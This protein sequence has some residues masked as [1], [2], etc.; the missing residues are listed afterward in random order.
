M[1][2]TL[3]E[4]I[5]QSPLFKHLDSPWQS[6]LVEASKLASWEA[7]EAII[8]E[9]SA[10]PHALYIVV[11][12]RVRVWTSAEGREVELKTLGAGAYFGEVSLL[13]GKE[14]TATVEPKGEQVTLVVLER[15]TLLELIGDDDKVRRM[16][17]GVTLARAKDTIGKVLE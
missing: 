1:T 15:N 12:G 13:S 10:A 7:G 8:E 5:Q 2:A 17:E 14:A 4:T 3:E 16:L 9:G 6:R 11:S